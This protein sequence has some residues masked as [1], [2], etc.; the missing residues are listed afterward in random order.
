[1]AIAVTCQCGR[2]FSAPAHLAGKRVKCPACG[3]PIDVVAQQAAPAFDPLG[4]A[5]HWERSTPAAPA[6]VAHWPAP[7]RP[8]KPRKP[9]PMR[10]VVRI[11]GIV[12]LVLVVVTPVAVFCGGGIYGFRQGWMRAQREREALTQ[13]ADAPWKEFVSP[14]NEYTVQ[15]P[16]LV[17]T[18]TDQ[19]ETLG[20]MTERRRARNRAGEMYFS[21]DARDIPPS[22]RQSSRFVGDCVN[23]ILSSIPDSN[24]QYK[25]Q[26]F[27]KF[28]LRYESTIE[29]VRYLHLM[30]CERNES[31]LFIVETLAPADKF[32][33]EQARRFIDSFRPSKP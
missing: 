30:R 2:Q 16:A 20:T 7:A 33:D 8:T 22:H 32:S 1:M 31:V 26:G 15:M 9:F 5:A 6:P 19:V 21:V 18:K 14:D 3:G 29:G 11:A 12:L 17:S 24:A 13:G 25:S 4:D 28:E 10:R 23:A 27:E